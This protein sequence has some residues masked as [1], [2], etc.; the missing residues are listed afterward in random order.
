MII[1]L[2]IVMS[3]FWGILITDEFLPWRNFLDKI[4]MG[5]ERKIGSQIK[6]VDNIFSITHKL[7]NCSSCFSSWLCGFSILILLNSGIG[8]LLMPLSYFLSFFIKKYMTTSI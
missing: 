1:L 7:L 5:Y 3:S 6:I 4:G 8:F 2:I